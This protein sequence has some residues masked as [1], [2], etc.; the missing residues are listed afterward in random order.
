MTTIPTLNQLYTSIVT[1][2]ESQYSISISFFGKVFLRAMAM[3]QAGKLKILYLVLG[4]LQKN[5]FIDTAD[6]ESIGGTLERFGR[7]K[8]GRNPFPPVAGEY[9][10][11]V[12]GSIGALIKAQTTFKSD[13]NNA[14]SGYLFVLDND[15]TLVA[16]TDTVTVRALT[17]GE[18]SELNIND[19]LTATAPIS[20]VDSKVMVTSIT[21]QPLASE[22]IEDYRTKALNS[23][24]LEPQGGASTD[25]MLWSQDVQG[26]QKVYPYAKSNAPSEINLFVEATIADSTDGKGTPTVTILNDVEAVV[27][28]NPDVSLSV[29]ERGRRPLQVIVN[30]LPITLLNVDIT[31]TNFLNLTPAIQTKV[32]SAIGDLI[33][34]IR[35]FIDSSE[36]LSDKKD[37]LDTNTLIATI[38]SEMPG[39]VFT[40]VNFTISGTLQTNYQFLL[41]NIPYNNSISFV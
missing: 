26:V 31:I 1:D 29:L 6:S 5:I 7:V 10:L 21:V 16:T 36:D 27:N 41:G 35:P 32:S 33:N 12:T 30:Y 23:Y 8:L 39:A 37:I 13:D 24:R 14:N 3:A 11:T 25:Y 2:L 28:F 38:V 34:S 15:Y 22:D 40:S 17:A 4:N 9:E 19:T 18:E 20:L